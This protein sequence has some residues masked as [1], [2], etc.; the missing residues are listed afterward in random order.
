LPTYPFQRP[1]ATATA[2]DGPAL[3]GRL[4]AL[5]EAERERTVAELVRSVT[6]A[7]LSLPDPAA[8]GAGQAFRDLGLDSVTAIEL[9]NRLNEATGLALPHTVVFD[10]PTPRSLTGRILAEALGTRDEA[11][12]DTTTAAWDEPVAIV[13]MSCRLP[14]GIDTPEALWQLL[15]E[16]GDAVSALPGD[17]GWDVEGLYDPEPGRPGR[18]YQRE[19]ALLHDAA[20]FDPE[21]FGISPREALAMDPQQR[22]LLETG[23]EVLERA[24]IDPA[25]LRGTRTGTF[26]GAMTQDYGPRLYE[27]PEDVS[28]YLLTGNTASVAS[29]RLAYTF[30]FEGPAVTVDTA[31][32][33]SLVALHLAAQSLRTGECSLALAGG[34]TV[35]PSAGSFIEFSK[36]RALAPDGRS[37]AFSADA[38]GFG[39]AEGTGMVLLERLSDARRNGHQ[40]LA[41]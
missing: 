14:G 6:A 1:G 10:H 13:A 20:D 4:A 17:R 29:G 26:V 15:T 30:G 3:R 16:G 36:Q 5:P 31:C 38:D 24:G 33:S 27:A 32:S 12:D 35:L 22:L 9:R 25:T 2:A 41:V 40:V 19:A 18:Y 23:W 34:V 7:L 37:K 11:T 39:L 28:G 8:V 21:F